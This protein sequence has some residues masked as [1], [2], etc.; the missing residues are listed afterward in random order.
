MKKRHLM[1]K[2]L[3]TILIGAFVFLL[4]ACGS[5][6][7]NTSNQRNVRGLSD[8]YTLANFLSQ[9]QPVIFYDVD[10]ISKDKSPRNIYYFKD[11]K[12]MAI[13]TQYH[14]NK[15]IGELSKMK[16][17]EIIDFYIE[18]EKS[19]FR[20]YQQKNV[21]L[22]KNNEQF[23]QPFY[24]K[25]NHDEI[26]M[27]YDELVR[28]GEEITN[29]DGIPYNSPYEIKIDTD[30]TGNNTKTE[31]ILYCGIK[32]PNIYENGDI[33]IPFLYNE[34]Y[35]EISFNIYATGNN[36][37]IY[38]TF[39]AVL[40]VESGASGDFLMTRVNDM[41]TTITLDKVGAKGTVTDKLSDEFKQKMVEESSKRYDE[42]VRSCPSIKKYINLTENN[43]D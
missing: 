15:T 34:R 22:I 37:P 18:T 9:R 39:Y 4:M 43:K 2:L 35:Y 8:Q 19:Y 12:I 42:F 13:S 6:G 16:D 26:S 11:D 23:K 24:S 7:G 31:S 10:E 40:A 36:M 28:L 20:N 38:N 27:T 21:D 5:N 41:S 17:N 30:A 14:E 3:L 25:I 1:K 33:E 29:Y 32:S